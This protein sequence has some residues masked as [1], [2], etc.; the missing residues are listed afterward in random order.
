V[1]G[2]ITP[3]FDGDYD[4]QDEQN[5]APGVKLDGN[6][7][8]FYESTLADNDFAQLVSSSDWTPSKDV[9]I[10]AVLFTNHAL[11]GLANVRKLTF[12]GT[13]VAR[14][15]ALIF[16][17]NLFMNHDSRV[18]NPQAQALNLPLSLQRPQLRSWQECPASGCSP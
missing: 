9:K 18:V 1:C 4:Q 14:D 2:G 15:D 13:V 17:T 8:K 5:G 3:C 6:P 11:A 16:G 10:D 7:R 12:N